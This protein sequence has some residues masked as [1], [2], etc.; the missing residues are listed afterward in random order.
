M[1][2]EIKKI[3]LMLSNLKIFTSYYLSLYQSA[4]LGELTSQQLHCA[5]LNSD[6]YLAI[7]L[8]KKFSIRPC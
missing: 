5:Q 6:I 1:K 2:K 8:I 4:F 7:S 3:I